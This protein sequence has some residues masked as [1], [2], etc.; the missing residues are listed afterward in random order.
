MSTHNDDLIAAMHRLA[1]ARQ[2]FSAAKERLIAAED[3]FREA[4]AALISQVEAARFE[5]KRTEDDARFLAIDA[6]RLS[7]NN[8]PAPGVQIKMFT[9]LTY[10]DE[11]ALAWAKEHGLAIALDRRVFEKIAVVDPPAFVGVVQEPVATIS[12]DL[13]SLL[14]P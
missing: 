1:A 11:L 6:Y 4:N 8:H 12:T 3:T 14:S 13:S 2:A 7:A 5:T 10:N 9:R